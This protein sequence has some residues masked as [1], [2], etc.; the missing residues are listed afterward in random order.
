MSNDT[1]KAVAELLAPMLKKTL[2]VAVSRV[3]ALESIP[4]P[5]AKAA[6]GARVEAVDKAA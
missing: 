3:A 1:W 5:A 4:A 6:D 2:F